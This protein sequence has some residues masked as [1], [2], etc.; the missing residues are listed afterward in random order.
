LD[1][2]FNMSKRA[3]NL[4]RNNHKNYY[5]LAKLY[6]KFGLLSKAI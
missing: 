4:G 6:Y 1:N 2:A 3:I 5:T